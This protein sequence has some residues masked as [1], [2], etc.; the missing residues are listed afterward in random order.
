MSDNAAALPIT[1]KYFDDKIS[2][3]EKI[4]IGD[5][6]DLRV[7]RVTKGDDSGMVESY[8]ESA[9][10]HRN[11]DLFLYSRDDF[12]KIYLGVGMILPEGYEAHIAPR[13][14]TFKSYG[15]TQTNS[16]GVVDESY[17]GEEDEWFVPCYA[18]R[19]GKIEHNDR[20][21][22]FR[23]MCKMP[24]VRFEEGPLKPASRGGHGSTGVK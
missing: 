3:L 7:S 2:R 6:I 8:P 18:L 17:C 4:A 24:A 14:G 5:W 21:F 20:A 9:M 15:L 10:F 16:V 19:P 12:L 1:I 23:I 13:G 22:Q 11:K